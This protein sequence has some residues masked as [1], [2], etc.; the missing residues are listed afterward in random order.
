MA[1]NSDSTVNALDEGGDDDSSSGNLNWLPALAGVAGGIYGNSVN[2]G[3]FDQSTQ[4]ANAAIQRLMNL[5]TPPGTAK[6]IVLQQYQQKGQLTPQLEQYIKAGPSQVAGIT[7]DPALKQRQMSALNL[8]S[9]RATGGLNPEDRAKFNE[10]RTQLAKEQEAKQ[11][12]LQQA[13]QARGMGGSG[14]ELAAALQNQQSGANQ[15]STQGDQLAATASQ[16]ALQ[17]ALQSGQLGGQIRQ[18]DFNVNQA[19][20]SAA[21]EMN[22]F[23]VQNQTNSQARNVNAQNQ[24]QA[25]N[26][27]TGQQLANANTSAANNELYRQNTAKLTDYNNQTALAKTQADAQKQKAKEEWDRSQAEANRNAQI[28]QGIGTA[29]AVAAMNKGGYVHGNAPYKGDHIQNDKVL[30]MLS[31]GEIVLP[32]SIVEHE[33]APVHAAHYVNVLKKLQKDGKI[34]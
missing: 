22:R 10:I 5:G 25:Y 29:V 19:R 9:Q 30:T 26:V 12:Q 33:D 24:A 20:A 11:Q 13:Y 31:P 8:L 18:Q 2:Q 4:D 32:K 16:N 1:D 3:G 23:N 21:D 34:G 28:A 27:G 7:E 15:A 6:Q 14:A 17:A